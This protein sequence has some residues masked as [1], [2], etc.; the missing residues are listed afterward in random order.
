[1]QITLDLYTDYLLSSFGQTSATGLS[2]LTDGAV[3]HDAVTDLLNRLQGD[4]R[5]LWQHVKSLIR[6]IQESDGVLLTDDSIAHKPHTDENGLVTT[7]YNHTSGDYVRGIN[8]V[9]LLYQTRKGQCPLSFEP[10]LKVQQCELK[11]RK[12][13]WPV[14]RCGSERTKHQMFQDMVRQAHQNAVS[15]RY[16]LA[17]SWYTNSDNIN[18]ILSLK[19]HYLGAVKSNLEVALSKH[20]RANGKFVKISRLKLQPGTVLTVFIRSVQAPVA[21]CGDIFPNKD[22]SVGELFLLTTDVTMTYQQLLTTYQK[23]WGIEEYH[24]SLKQNASLEKSPTRTH[25]TQSNH[26]FAS[27]YAYVKLERLRLTAHTNHFALKGQ[28]YLKAMQA[29]FAELIV[30]KNQLSRNPEMDLA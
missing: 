16:V 7:H 29:A 5:T 12:V 23:R 6:Q 10:V 22:G 25:R 28:L 11:T 17:D 27:I 24:K 15:F 14:R 26:L 1:M 9:S 4:N 20:D 30:L 2:R 3:G 13:V 8:F 18:L 21:I 19:H